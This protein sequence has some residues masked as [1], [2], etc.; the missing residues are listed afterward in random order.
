MLKN[1][2]TAIAASALLTLSAAAYANPA[3]TPA[4]EAPAAAAPVTAPNFFD[5][6]YWVNSFTGSTAQVST[7]LTFNAAHPSAWMKW[8]DPKSQIGR[9]HV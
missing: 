2:L 4:T 6:N 3:E 9:A 1:K 5:P 7:E 8:A